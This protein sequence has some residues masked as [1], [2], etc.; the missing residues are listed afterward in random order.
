MDNSKEKPKE[1]PREAS[2]TASP[3]EDSRPENYLKNA[4]MATEQGVLIQWIENMS[5]YAFMFMKLYAKE[6]EDKI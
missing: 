1:L 5:R 3:S 2:V 6:W 4:E